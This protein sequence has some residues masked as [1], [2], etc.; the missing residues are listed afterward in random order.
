VAVVNAL[1]PRHVAAAGTSP[2][3]AATTYEGLKRRLYGA[4]CLA[5]G[6]HFVP[7]VVDT[8]GA[9]GA[10]AQPHLRMLGEAWARTHGVHRSG[11]HNFV[12]HRVGVAIAAGVADALLRQEGICRTSAGAG[13]PPE[14]AVGGPAL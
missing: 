1:G 6:V 9:L 7:F 5:A 14:V 12:R 4:R 11:A 8:F 2:G 3:A 10:S 13:P